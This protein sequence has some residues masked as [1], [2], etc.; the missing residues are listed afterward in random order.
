MPITDT[1]TGRL[2]A[3]LLAW[4]LAS[5]GAGAGGLYATPRAY[6]RGFWFMTAMWG[7]I[8]GGIAWVGLVRPPVPPAGLAP[9]LAVNAGLDVGYLIAAG[10]LATR[11]NPLLR[12]FGAAVAVQ[13]VF[14]LA[15]D[16][17]FRR[18]AVAAIAGG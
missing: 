3:V 4:A 5:L 1:L 6:W 9:I 11:R 2:L 16:L 7:L 13:A 12:G 15:L 10:V 14:L 17:G 8:D 18:A